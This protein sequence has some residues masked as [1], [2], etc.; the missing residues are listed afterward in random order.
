MKATTT[1]KRY[2]T[3]TRVCD[4]RCPGRGSAEVSNTYVMVRNFEMRIYLY[5]YIFFIHFLTV[6]FMKH[7]RSP[8]SYE[9]TQ[10]LEEKVKRKNY[11][12]EQ[13]RLDSCSRH[14]HRHIVTMF[15]TCLRT[16]SC[17][18][19]MIVC[20]ITALSSKMGR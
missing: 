17:H 18:V 9:Q 19:L 7:A 10:G 12:Q 13:L 6:C 15:V 2:S 11:P 5:I 8:F 1:K 3:A 20:D 16:P 14:T 4:R